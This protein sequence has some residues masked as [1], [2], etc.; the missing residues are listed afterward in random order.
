[1]SS[2]IITS[3]N[4]TLRSSATEAAGNENTVHIAQNCVNVNVVTLK[5]FAVYPMNINRTSCRNTAV[6]ECFV[7]A[8][9]AVVKLNIFADHCN[10]Y[11]S[12][13]ISQSPKHLL[14]IC[15]ILLR[16]FN[17]QF[18]EH[19]AVHILFLE[20]HRY[21]IKN[22]AVIV[23]NNTFLVNITEKRNFVFDIVRHMMLATANDNI[24]V[25]TEGEHFLNRMLRRL[26]FQLV[27][28][29]KIRNERYV[30]E[31]AVFTAV[32]CRKLTNSLQKRLTFDIA[33]CTADFNKTDICAV[34]GILTY[35]SFDF[36][37]NVR[38]NLDSLTA[39]NALTLVADYLPVNLARCKI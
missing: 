26:T 30:N 33:D 9:I 3:D 6:L 29:R 19:N 5:T 15:Q 28:R 38:N 11:R 16:C 35:V 13:R 10:F 27:G 7:Y 2:R 20:H 39:V 18:L 25:N 24:G 23:F 4:L 37:R 21:G 22:I 32:L 8:D 1:M 12:L 31:K 36:I 14:P 17:S 34:F